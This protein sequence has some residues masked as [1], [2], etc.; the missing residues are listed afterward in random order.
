MTMHEPQTGSG[1]Y[2]SRLQACP[3]DLWDEQL[4][5]CTHVSRLDAPY[6]MS[7]QVCKCCV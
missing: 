3:E 7:S 4:H 5:G 1:K 6:A 2:T